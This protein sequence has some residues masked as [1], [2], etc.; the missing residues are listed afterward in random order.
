MRENTERENTEREDG[1]PG[2]G[3]PFAV[4]FPERQAQ[5]AAID[6]AIDEERRPDDPGVIHPP[7]SRSRPRGNVE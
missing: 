4:E 6:P 5:L 7:P 3:S 2:T 1:E